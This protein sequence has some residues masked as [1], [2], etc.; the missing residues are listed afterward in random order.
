MAC[1]TAVNEQLAHL[2]PI[3]SALASSDLQ[4]CLQLITNINGRVGYLQERLP[5][6]SHIGTMFGA[7]MAAIHVHLNRL[8]PK[9]PQSLIDNAKKKKKKKTKDKIKEDEEDEEDKDIDPSAQILKLY[10]SAADDTA[11]LVK[12]EAARRRRAAAG[13][14]A[15]A[16]AAAEESSD[17]EDGDD[18]GGD[19][20][21]PSVESTPSTATRISIAQRIA[22][23]V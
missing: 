19:D 16:A 8:S 15:A 5:G 3:Y 12:R 11:F 20:Q 23:Q 22:Q 2:V 1:A 14:A 10:K 6:F 7:Q 17:N 18:D 13:A 4:C 9:Y 21:Q